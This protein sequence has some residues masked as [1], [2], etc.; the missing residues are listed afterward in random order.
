VINIRRSKL[1]DPAE[2]GNAGSFFKNPSVTEKEFESLKSEFPQIVGYKNSDGT[3]KLAA[4][5]LIERCGWKG[6]RRGDVGCN[7]RQ[8]LVLVNFGNAN[9]QEVLDLSDEIQESVRGKFSVNLEREVN[10]I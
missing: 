5:W 2:I 4:A 3:V 9:G 1:P 7:E 10:I 8:P 6:Y